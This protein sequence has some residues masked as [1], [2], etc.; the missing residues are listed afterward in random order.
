MS[1]IVSTWLGIAFLGL[2]VLAVVLQAWL[3]GPKFWNAEL[4]KTMAP[5][6][7]LRVHALC[8][9]AYAAIYFV[10]MWHMLPRLWEYQYELP[11][12]TVFHAVVAITI[13]VLLL[14]KI[15][16]LLFF[17]HFEESMPYYGF[18]IL[19]STV[20]LIVLS[21]P[22]AI[23]AQDLLG[24]AMTPENVAR[25]DQLLAEVEFD[26]DVDRA[27]LTTIE[28][29][30]RGKDVLVNK[31]VVCHDMRT[32]LA[33]PRPAAAWYDLNTRML[34]KPTIFRQQ[35]SHEDIPYVTAYLVAIT[36]DIQKSVKQKREIESAERARKDATAV[37]MHDADAREVPVVSEADG[38]TLLQAHCTECHGLEDVD[39]HGPDDLAGWRSVVAA[40][41]EEGAEYT[42]EQGELCAVYLAQKYP[43]EE[44]AAV[45]VIEVIEIE[46]EEEQDVEEEAPPTVEAK[47]KPRKRKASGSAASGR[48]I[49]QAKC[50]ACHGP[51]GK[52][53]TAYG[54]KVGIRSLARTSLSRG[55]VKA[56]IA[57]GMPGTKMK[58][59]RDKLT[60]TQLDD[61]TAF[62]KALR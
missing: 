62:V 55:R 20:I 45:E 51:D 5:K 34:E 8:G 23:R 9:Y 57:D 43:A 7:W 10:M 60:P 1:T 2:A 42:E 33:K 52:G 54:K 25:V 11:A 15:G 38:E 21:V 35:L 28:G 18:G 61:V 59:Y 36:P 31:C 24:D 17:R 49:F 3:W 40:M 4:G 30:T 37:A 14:C 47:P 22:Y 29:L 58:A 53:N 19:L 41:V 6:G 39:A 16:I 56:I 26:E 46:E 48:P 44:E 50:K 32:I 13:G 12:R 27:A